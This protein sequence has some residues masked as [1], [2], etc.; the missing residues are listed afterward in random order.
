MQTETQP[1]AIWRCVFRWWNQRKTDAKIRNLKSCAGCVAQ[2]RTRLNRLLRAWSNRTFFAGLYQFC[3][4]S[5]IFVL[6]ATSIKQAV[7]KEKCSIFTS[8]L[9]SDGL[10]Y[11]WAEQILF[12]CVKPTQ[13]NHCIL[14]L[15]KKWVKS[16]QI[17]FIW[18][19]SIFYNPFF[20]KK[21]SCL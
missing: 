17:A 15:T 2:P 10:F 14:L 7:W 8:C 4:Y 12:P 6:T 18:F 19:K 13:F 3:T 16:A 9:F 20:E 1:I 21:T 11:A 5:T